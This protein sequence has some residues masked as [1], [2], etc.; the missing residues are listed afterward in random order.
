MNDDVDALA[1]ELSTCD[2]RAL[3]AVACAAAERVLPFYDELGSGDPNALR[4]PVDGFWRWIEQGIL[5]P[6]TSGSRAT[7]DEYADIHYEEGDDLMGG[8]VASVLRCI[9]TYEAREV[10]DTQALEAA[11]A[12]V[13]HADTANAIAVLLEGS[14]VAS[15]VEREEGPWRDRI[16]AL[17]RNPPA[18]ITR[19]AFTLDAPTWMPELLRAST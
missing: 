7:L 11:R 10:P 18:R 16:V 17:A 4:A 19:E 8:V 2:S 13:L 5:A 15:R 3:L 14:P 12:L 1:L 9:A 6:D